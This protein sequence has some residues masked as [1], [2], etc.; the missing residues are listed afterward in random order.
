[1]KFKKMKFKKMKF[2]KMKNWKKIVS[3]VSIA[4]D[5]LQVTNF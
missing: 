1:M 3:S 4:K 2:N 5:D